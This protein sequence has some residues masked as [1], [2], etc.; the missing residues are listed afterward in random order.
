MKLITITLL[1]N[2]LALVVANI[3]FAQVEAFTSRAFYK[4]FVSEISS[5]LNQVHIGSTQNNFPTGAKLNSNLMEVHLGTDIPVLYGQNSQFNWALS[6]P[7]SLHVL[8][9][10]FE[11]TTAPIVNNDYRFG[12]SFTGIK[13]LNKGFVQNIAVKITPFAHESTHLG[14]ELTIFGTQHPDQFY[15][16]NVSYEYYELG[17]CLNDPDTLSGNV[18]SVKAG[19][20]GLLNPQKGYYS[21][22]ENET[23]QQTIHSSRRWCEYYLQVNYVK[24]QGLLTTATWHPELSIEARNRVKYNYQSTDLEDR[25]WCINAYAGYSYRPK[26]KKVLKSVG[27]YFRYY[28]GI[29]PHGQFR[30]GNY[31]FAGYAIVAFL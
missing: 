11:E 19:F 14:D 24:T 7:V 6:A 5:T 15:R 1:A 13:Y 12:M 17:L 23:Y 8:W 30:N 10:A 29:N 21:S 3:A 31:T 2:I 22:F 27:H 4:P 18:L 9:A 26:N 20:M 28:N 16:I 25:V